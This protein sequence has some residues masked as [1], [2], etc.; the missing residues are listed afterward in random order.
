MLSVLP[1]TRTDAVIFPSSTLDLISPAA[2]SAYGPTE[3][4]HM[5][6]K[7]KGQGNRHDGAQPQSEHQRR[8]RK[9][10]PSA[11]I[12]A[13]SFSRRVVSAKPETVSSSL[14]RQ[15][16][17]R[18]WVREKKEPEQASDIWDLVASMRLAMSRKRAFSASAFF[19]SSS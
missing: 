10:L 16:A 8:P 7:T 12:I 9:P 14:C 3:H 1:S 4:T 13:S 6:N 2:Y 11:A 18:T 17:C 15:L 5:T 19:F